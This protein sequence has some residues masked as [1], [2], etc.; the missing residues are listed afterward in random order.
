MT[1]SA[2]VFLSELNGIRTFGTIRTF[3]TNYIVFNGL[4]FIR[5][6]GHLLFCPNK[7]LPGHS[8]SVL[9]TL[10][11]ER[12]VRMAPIEIGMPMMPG[13]EEGFFKMQEQIDHPQRQTYFRAVAKTNCGSARRSEMRTWCGA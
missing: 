3:K 8:D 11:R 7:A 12:R 9:S 2:K 6:F 5:P 4:S 13:R 10:R 1:Y